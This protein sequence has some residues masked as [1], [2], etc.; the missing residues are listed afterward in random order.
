[1][2]KMPQ[3]E[4]IPEAWSAIADQR[5][6]IGEN[7]A[8]V[9]SSD[10]TKFYTVTWDGMRYRSNDNASYWQNTLGYPVIAVLM[11]Q[12]KIPY[13]PEIA[14]LFA[15]IPWK[16]VNTRFKNKYKEALEYVLQQL[17][18]RQ[19]D[20]KQVEAAMAADYAALEQLPVTLVKSKLRPPGNK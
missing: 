11:V 9:Y 14:A 12:G 6:E 8:R 18:D 2:K 4:K 15:N 5:V 7:E 10:R 3:L 16:E 20:L 13:N 17:A 1:M 19:V